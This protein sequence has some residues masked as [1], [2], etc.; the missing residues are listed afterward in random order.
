MSASGHMPRPQWLPMKN[1][2]MPPIIRRTMKVSPE[3]CCGPYS[4]CKRCPYRSKSALFADGG[5]R[6]EQVAGKIHVGHA[7][8]GQFDG[9]LG[10]KQTSIRHLPSCSGS[11]Q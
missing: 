10:D 4:S 3:S 11:V 6:F 7:A 2:A 8:I 1:P 9:F 5:Q